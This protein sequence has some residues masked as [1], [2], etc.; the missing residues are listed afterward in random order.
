M[1]YHRRISVHNL[2]KELTG[3]SLH[4]RSELLELRP[5]VEKARGSDSWPPSTRDSTVDLAAG[6]YQVFI[7]VLHRSSSK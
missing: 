3:D 4:V 2:F 1:Q 6:K 7:G 5:K